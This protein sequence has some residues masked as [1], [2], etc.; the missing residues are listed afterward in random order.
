LSSKVPLC[1]DLANYVLDA[2]RQH[3]CT[4]WKLFSVTFTDYD[5]TLNTIVRNGGGWTIFTSSRF[6]SFSEDNFAHKL[7]GVRNVS[8]VPCGSH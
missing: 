4:D 6:Y 1:L 2:E 7:K 8:Y 5:G 3:E